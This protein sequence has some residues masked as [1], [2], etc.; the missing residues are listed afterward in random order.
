MSF[1]CPL[2]REKTANVREIRFVSEPTVKE[3]VKVSASRLLAATEFVPKLKRAIFVVRRD[4]PSSIPH[5]FPA[6]EQRRQDAW[7]WLVLYKA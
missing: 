7:L 1:A 3:K 4:D 6:V 5:L 2:A